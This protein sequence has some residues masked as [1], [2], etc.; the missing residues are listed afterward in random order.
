MSGYINK[1]STKRCTIAAGAAVSDAVDIQGYKVVG[2]YTLETWTAA[3][4]AIQLDPTGALTPADVRSSE[5][6]LIR[7]D[8]FVITDIFAF[9][10]VD[11]SEAAGSPPPLIGVRAAVR[12]V[13]AASEANVNQVAANTVVLLL[14]H[15]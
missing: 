12:S 11:V 2:A 4:L 3:D 1:F 9:G 14:E 5:G 6:T 8:G 13:N 10:S 15:L 7:I